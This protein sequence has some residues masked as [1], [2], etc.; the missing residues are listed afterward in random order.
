MARTT[1]ISKRIAAAAKKNQ[2]KIKK[3]AVETYCKS[4]YEVSLSTKDGRLPYGFMM[5][6]VQENK[7][8]SPWLNQAMMNSAWKRYKREVVNVQHSERNPSEIA[9]FQIS[10]TCR[11]KTMNDQKM[12]D[13]QEAH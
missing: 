8:N 7:K 13:Q 12:K 5:K 2:L 9:P 3:A 10:V 6:F 4:I 11:L 1:S